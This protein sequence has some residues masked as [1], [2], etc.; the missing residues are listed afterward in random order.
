MKMRF[1]VVSGL[2]LMTCAA[3]AAGVRK[4][5][6]F[7]ANDSALAGYVATPPAG[8]A[9]NY[10]FGPASPA[11]AATQQFYAITN[12]SSLT[13]PTTLPPKAAITI[14]GPTGAIV[15]KELL[16]A[17]G[18]TVLADCK[19]LN[20]ATGLNNVC[21]AP[22]VAMVGLPQ[23]LPGRMLV[24]MMKTTYTM[25]FPTGFKVWTF[26]FDP[27]AP[28]GSVD[29]WTQIDLRTISTANVASLGSGF[30]NVFLN[31]LSVNTNVYV[32][33]RENATSTSV[34]RVTN[35]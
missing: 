33:T 6:L 25:N 28:I 27:A 1:V 9:L 22:T 8:W 13:S 11:T 21:P 3:Q 30:A 2:L 15:S 26:A 16:P 7:A 29:R 32:F 4:T 34:F 17:A 20:P 5:K 12:A 14:L 35:K 23:S 19:I 18:Q 24:S 10:T 31:Y